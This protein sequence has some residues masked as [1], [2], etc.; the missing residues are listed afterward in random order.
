M[1]AR[2]LELVPLTAAQRMGMGGSLA[3]RSETDVRMMVFQVQ[4]YAASL[5][6]TAVGATQLATGASELAM[7]ILKYA[8]EGEV[9]W[10]T[11]QQGLRQGMELQARD[12]GPGIPD[13]AKALEEH[14]SSKGTLGLGLPGTRRLMDEFWID[15]EPRKGTRVCVRKW[16]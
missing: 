10:H 16:K 6:F 11:V 2:P 9:R 14:Y 15:S 5:G 7:N 13:L 1:S 8:G 12:K 3:I 4:A